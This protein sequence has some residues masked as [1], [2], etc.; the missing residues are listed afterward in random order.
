MKQTLWIARNDYDRGLYHIFP[1]EPHKNEHGIFLAKAFD[2]KMDTYFLE[3]FIS[4][5]KLKK[6]E[7]KPFTI[8]TE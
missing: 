5:L 1:I 7:K 8:T 2:M 3:E 6:G 4:I